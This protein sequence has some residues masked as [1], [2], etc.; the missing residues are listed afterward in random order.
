MTEPD[1]IP[2]AWCLSCET[3]EDGELVS[4]HVYPEYGAP[5]ESSMQC[6]CSP[7]PYSRNS[8]GVV[9]WMHREDN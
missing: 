7:F 6:R 1:Q 4:A 2:P 3:D 9:V 5:H 8:V